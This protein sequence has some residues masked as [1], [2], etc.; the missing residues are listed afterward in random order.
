MLEQ[1]Y[2]YYQ[3]HKAELDAQYEGRFIVIVGESVLGAFDSPAAAAEAAKAQNNA[4]GS[5][6]VQ[7]CSPRQDQTQ[8]FHSRAAF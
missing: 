2:R 4:P 8:H 7:F 3:E 6:L 5:F 1:E